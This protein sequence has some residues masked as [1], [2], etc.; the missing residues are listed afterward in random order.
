MAVLVLDWSG[1]PDDLLGPVLW[2]LSPASA[3]V[4]GTVVAID[5]GVVAD[6][7]VTLEDGGMDVE[8]GLDDGMGSYTPIASFQDKYFMENVTE[9]IARS[10]YD[11]DWH[12][13]NARMALAYH[14]ADH[15]F[16]QSA[17]CRRAAD[18]FLGP[19]EG[20]GDILFNAVDTRRFVPGR[21]AREGEPFFQ[22]IGSRA[23]PAPS[24]TSSGAR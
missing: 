2:L 6:F 4:T 19:R 14:A 13:M 12:A 10:W 20:P 3:F 17:F 9:S 22:L 5:G 24:G 7:P 16:W 8:P 15:V 23:D 11:G 1:V 18:I 21:P